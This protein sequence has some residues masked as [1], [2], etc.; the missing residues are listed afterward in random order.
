VDQRI[1]TQTQFDWDVNPSHRLTTILTFDPQNND[2]A[3]IDTFDPQLV[4]ADYRQRVGSSVLLRIAGSCQ[5]ALCS[6]SSSVKLNSRVF[7]ADSLSA[8]MTLYPEQNSGSFFE[9]QRRFTWLY[10]W[11]QSLHFHPLSYHGRH[12]LT[13]GYSFSR[14]TYDGTVSNLPVQVRREDHTLSSEISYSDALSSGATRN[15]LALFVQDNWQLLPRFALDLGL[16]LDH[17]SL[18]SDALYAAPRVGFIYAPRDNRTAIRGGVGL[19]YDRSHST[20]PPSAIFQRRRSRNLRRW[21]PSCS[22]PYVHARRG[23]QQW[24]ASASV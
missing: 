3:N 6:L 9:S 7:P 11:S 19:F 2:Y 14:S 17:D 4:T 18:A 24:P 22:R 8:K 21:M 12:L 15:N 16:R 1:N 10:Q 23:S 13:V 5:G 20:S